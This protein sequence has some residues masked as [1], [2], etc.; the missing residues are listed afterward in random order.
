MTNDLNDILG[1]SGQ[2][3]RKRPPTRK[4]DRSAADFWTFRRMITPVII[5][6]IFC[7][8]VVVCITG[9]LLLVGAGVDVEQ[10]GLILLGVGLILVGPIA[11]RLYCELAILFF[12]MNET[13][14]DIKNHIGKRCV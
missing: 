5:Q 6:G 7:I 9:G 3:E 14:T 8:G 12:R 11:I 1:I 13:L 10:P 4:S 2:N